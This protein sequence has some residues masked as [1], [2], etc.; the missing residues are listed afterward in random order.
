MAARFPGTALMSPP[1]SDAP[2]PA[3]LSATEARIL[4]SLVEKEATT[5]EAYPLTA[6]AVQLAC[7]QKNNREPILELEAGEV[8]H[9]LRE[10][11]SRGL[12]QSVHGARAQ[13]YEHRLS[14]VY[15]L[16]RQQQALV[17][18]LLLRGPQTAAELLTRCERLNGP[19]ELE[20]AR[21]QLERLIQRG[22][23]VNLGRGAGQRED[24]YMHLLGG[25][26]S[27]ELLAAAAPRAASPARSSLEARVE[28]LEAEVVELR[29]QV[30][31]LLAPAD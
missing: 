12:V 21:Q 26:V 7:N 19:R 24:R 13:R 5:P 16:T 9:A 30:R 27:P 22:L 20:D 2:G 25:P 23:A 10:L 14:A 1:E 6:N 15:S 3:P 29:D 18:V 17:S 31:R 8:G 4:G 28:A 11:E